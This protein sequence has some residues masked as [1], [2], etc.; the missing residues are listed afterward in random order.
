MRFE[1]RVGRYLSAEPIDRVNGVGSYPYFTRNGRWVRLKDSGRDDWVTGFWPGILWLGAE[2]DPTL[3][4][5]AL[6]KTRRIR[7]RLH[8]NFNIGFRYLN[9]WVP[10]YQ[11]TPSDERLQPPLKAAQRL[12]SCYHPPARVLCHVSGGSELITANDAMM[13]LPLLMWAHRAVDGAAPYRSVCERMLNRAQKWFLR[14]DGGVHHLLRLDTRSG[15]VRGVDSPQGVEGGC[16]ARGLAWM[17]T[18]L[19]L[20]GIAL[21]REDCLQNARRLAEYHF[22]RTDGSIPPYDYSLST[23][24]HPEWIDTSAAVILA[25]GQLI[26]GLLREDKTA[27]KRGNRLLDGVLTRHARGEDQPG[28]IGGGCFHAPAGEGVNEAT[29]WGDYYALLSL[30]IRD[31]KTLPPH[32]EWLRPP[33]ARATSSTSNHKQE[34]DPAS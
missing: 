22:Q 13:N 28:L 8:G 32:L 33:P 5:V 30:Y 1:E 14:E 12:L 3:D 27:W 17:S 20:G 29:I 34:S 2:A 7:P 16:W 19:V 11:R 26:L 25:A 18:G 10:A 4:P 9:S 6:E 23:R 24:T 15:R 21:L 31:K